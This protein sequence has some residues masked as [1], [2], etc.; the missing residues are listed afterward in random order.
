MKKLYRLGFRGNYYN[1][2]K[3]FL[4]Y[5]KQFISLSNLNSDPLNIDFGTPQGSTLGSALFIL[6]INDITSLSL[7]GKI[8]LFADDAAIFYCETDINELNRKMT[9]DMT[10]I[11]R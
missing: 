1:L 3:S 10:N 2:I 9:E 8:I 7:H 4:S 6:F 11:S 5:R